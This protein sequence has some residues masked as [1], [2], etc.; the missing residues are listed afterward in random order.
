MQGFSPLSETV[1]TD[2]AQAELSAT[3]EVEI[4]FY[5][6]DSVQIVWHGNYVKYL[7]NGR[8]E[9]GR[10]FGLRYLDFFDNGYIIPI[11]DMHIRYMTPALYEQTLVVE[12]RYVPCRG[13]KLMYEYIIRRKSD[14]AVVAEASTTQLFMTK[15]GVFEASA[16]DF[17]RRWREKW[18]V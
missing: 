16:P 8:E 14:M 5:D 1:K 18:G 3:T 10:K 11:V 6:V 15:D 4:H 2:K 7:E 9:F 17:Y 12:T 13:A